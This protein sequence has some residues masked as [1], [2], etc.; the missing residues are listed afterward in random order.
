MI[1]YL[2]LAVLTTIRPQLP[3][4]EVQALCTVVV[5]YRP[6]LPCGSISGYN[7]RLFNPQ[8]TRQSTVR[9]VGSNGTFYIIK[10]EDRQ[11]RVDTIHVQVGCLS[12]LEQ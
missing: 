2:I 7:V 12:A 9:Y 11:D 6:Q 3:S 8:M 10:D 5:W 1:L 4:P